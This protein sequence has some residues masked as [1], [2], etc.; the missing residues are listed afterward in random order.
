MT[1]EEKNQLATFEARIRQLMFMYGK[2]KEKN[3]LLV[4]VLDKKELELQK[5]QHEYD[6]LETC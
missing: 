3:S 6:D 1:D 4:Q 5:L 2:L